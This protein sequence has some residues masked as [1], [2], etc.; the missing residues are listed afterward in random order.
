MTT[1]K[2]DDGPLCQ[3]TRFF[4]PSKEMGL[5]LDIWCSTKASKG[6]LQDIYLIL[7][8]LHH[9]RKPLIKTVVAG[10]FF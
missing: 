10:S 1:C 5:S 2:K 9:K 4:I 6:L 8:L 7:E 3:K